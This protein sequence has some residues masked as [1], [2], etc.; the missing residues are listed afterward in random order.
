MRGPA[1]RETRHRL[2]L[3]TRF[4]GEL[5]P[6]D[7]SDLSTLPLRLVR[8]V[9]TPASCFPSL[10][11]ALAFACSF[12][13]RQP[14]PRLWRVFFAWSVAIAVSTLTTKQ[15]Y[16]VDVIGGVLLSV[17]CVAVVERI[18]ARFVERL[19]PES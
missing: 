7:A 1:G 10:H 12:A 17:V 11:V 8:E 16:V 9:D 3:P 13:I 14:R 15:H 5:F 18:N 6:L 2:A 19:R 4:P